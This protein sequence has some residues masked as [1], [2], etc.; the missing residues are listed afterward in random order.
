MSKRAARR[1][2]R[3]AKWPDTDG[4]PPWVPKAGETLK[5]LAREA[6]KFAATLALEG[7]RAKH[8]AAVARVLD[9]VGATG[10][11]GDMATNL[12]SEAVWRAFEELED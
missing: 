7:G 8:D 10:R 11:A 5:V 9:S 3:L 12:A 6:V 1:A 4:V 2:R